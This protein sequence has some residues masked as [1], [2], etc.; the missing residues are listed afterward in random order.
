[1]RFVHL[2]VVAVAVLCLIGYLIAF[3]YSF[4]QLITN[5]LALEADGKVPL[6]VFLRSGLTWWNV[7]NLV[8]V[9]LG[10][11]GAA[12]LRARSLQPAQ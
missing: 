6:S 9:P 3:G 10:I 1:M 11:V 5:F 7:P 8:A 2:P 4:V 12:T